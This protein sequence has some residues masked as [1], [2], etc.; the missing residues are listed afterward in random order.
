MLMKMVKN[1]L[2][3][4]KNN[5][6]GKGKTKNSTTAKPTKVKQLQNQSVVKPKYIINSTHVLFL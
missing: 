4:Q 5:D 2:K 1:V 6:L 3:L